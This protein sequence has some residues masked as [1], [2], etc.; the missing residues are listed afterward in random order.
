MVGTRR[1]L[2]ALLAAVVIVPLAIAGSFLAYL[3]VNQDSM[4]FAATP[5][6]PDH[7]FLFDVP[8]E[9][10]TIAVEGAEI[11]ALHFKQPDPR[12]L[13]FFLHGNGGNLQTWTNDVEYYQRVNYDMFILDYRGYGKSTGQV[14][15][16]RQLHD[17]VR[18]A[19][20]LVAEDY[21]DKPI[22][23]YGRSLGSALATRLAIDVEPDLLIL[24]SPFSS[25]LAMAQQQYPYVPEWILRFPLRTDEL[26]ADVAVPTIIVHGDEDSFIPIAH[27]EQLHNL[28]KNRTEM[29]VIRGAGHGDIHRFR[30]YRDGLTMALPN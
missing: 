28:A 3:Y 26:I 7:Q 19:W 27:S 29:L 13:V 22:V 10:I 11:N 9:E 20:D 8:F 2:A 12:G 6:P 17:D 1:I 30:S 4:I 23:V 14:D 21:P 16:E 18:A 5:L 25:M 24:V 15:S